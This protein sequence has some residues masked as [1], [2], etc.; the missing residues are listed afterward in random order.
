MLVNGKTDEE[1]LQILN[2]C[3]CADF[4]NKT[5]KVLNNRV[6]NC[7]T[8]YCNK[9]GEVLRSE[10]VEQL[11]SIGKLSDRM[12][13]ELDIDDDWDFNYYIVSLEQIMQL[14]FM[15]DREQLLS[16]VKDMMCCLTK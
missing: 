6:D 8:I 10:L 5:D 1:Y 14:L 16:I 7:I 4:L 12:K 13:E 2:A 15:C 3:L 11:K 9:K